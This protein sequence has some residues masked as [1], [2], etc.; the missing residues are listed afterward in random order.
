MI[1]SPTEKVVTM[2]PGMLLVTY[3]NINVCTYV[4]YLLVFC[5]SIDYFHR[6]LWRVL[7]H[8]GGAS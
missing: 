2:R 4:T 1:S 3:G 6:F 8:T 5:V 7:T